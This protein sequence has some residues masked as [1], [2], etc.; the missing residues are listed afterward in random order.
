VQQ[1]NS[2]T[3]N[4][5]GTPAL[6]AP[7][8][9]KGRQLTSEEKT[10][11]L[12]LARIDAGTGLQ[13]RADISVDTV[14]DYADIMR[15]DRHKLPPVVTF[16]DGERYYLADGFH[17]H[18]AA[19]NIGWQT[20]PAVV[21]KGTLE[22][23]LKYALSANV[24]HGLPRTNADKRRS[25]ALALRQWPKLSNRE[26]AR[27]CAVS[28]HSVRDY[29]EA[30]CD[31]DAVET[32]IGADGKER[33]LPKHK[34]SA[35]ASEPTEPPPLKQTPP[36]IESGGQLPEAVEAKAVEVET[37]ATTVDEEVAEVTTPSLEECQVE[38]WMAHMQRAWQTGS[39][40]GRLAFIEW[41]KANMDE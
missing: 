35:I 17:R 23:A 5:S 28:E 18:C 27:I 20:I 21:H 26:I 34:R 14:A 11:E 33:K 2:A 19:K 13:I 41:A 24:A 10:V 15:Q 29:R 6:A 40:S 39:A 32:R 9:K 3:P 22:D 7:R 36:A 1:S 25:V 30:N 8:F 37:P 38:V 12:P 4:A 31:K 16:Y